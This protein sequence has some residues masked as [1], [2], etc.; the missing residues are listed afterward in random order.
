MKK[1]LAILCALGMMATLAACGEKDGASSEV[2][3]TEATTEV[4]TEATTEITTEAT[5]EATTEVTTETTTETDTT[6]TEEE[7]ADAESEEESVDADALAA[8]LTQ[9]ET[10]D[11]LSLSVSPNWTK[12][13]SLGYPMWY[14]EDMSGAFFVQ[15]FDTAGMGISSDTDHTTVLEQIGTAMSS[16]EQA[17]VIAEEWDTINGEEAYGV[18][19]TLETSGIATTNISVFF[20]VGETVCGITFTDFGGTGTVM[21]YTIPILDSITF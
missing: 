2:V 7:T 10:T 12:D 9:T 19:Y 18:T 21:D 8:E 16:Q 3:T 14:M 11:S 5:T 4:T 20:Y 6:T 17:V 13:E 15:E 1:I